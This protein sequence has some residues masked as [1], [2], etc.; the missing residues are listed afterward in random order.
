MFVSDSIT[1]ALD[2]CS[3][4]KFKAC[5]MTS[6]GNIW[7]NDNPWTTDSYTLS[8]ITESS[9]TEGYYAELNE[10]DAYVELICP[11]EVV[12]SSVYRYDLTADKIK[13]MTGLLNNN[14]DFFIE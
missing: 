7:P 12:I 10:E 6:S 11:N 4:L 3:G 8:T 14:R 2:A 5:I 13:N 9:P 1:F